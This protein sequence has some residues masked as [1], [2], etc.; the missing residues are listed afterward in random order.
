[1]IDTTAGTRL[2]IGPVV[3]INS[4]KA[5]TDEDAVSFFEAISG[6]DWIEVEEIESF[7][8]LGDN[9]EVAT[10]VSVKDRRVRKLKTTRDAG[11]MAVVVGRDPLDPGQAALKAAEKLDYNRAFKVLY[12]D[13]AD[14]EHTNSI[15][16]FG[17]L[18]LSRPTNLA[19]AAD[20][21]KRT[22]NIGVNTAVYEVVSE[23]SVVATNLVLPSIIGAAV[24]VGVELTAIEGEWTG[25]PSSY[26][27]QWQ[28]DASGNGSFTNVSVGGTGKKYTPVVGDV[29]D[30]LRVQVTAVNGAGSSS[31][32]NSLGT[33]PIIAA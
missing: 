26:T 24:Q 6:G 20:V 2:F 4:I 30:S 12:P 8:E 7:G 18:V 1:M 25:E 29:G 21:T 27:Y 19:G 28:H 9:S 13:A 11:T 33:I 14:D 22:F 31:A 10:F 3:N 32:A 16:Y 15:E 5:M 23:S 17:G